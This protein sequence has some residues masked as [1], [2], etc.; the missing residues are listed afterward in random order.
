[1][2]MYICIGT[3]FKGRSLEKRDC[4]VPTCVALTLQSLSVT[5][6]SRRRFSVLKK[7]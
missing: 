3:A 6:T 2:R 5:C 7:G 4:N 1:M